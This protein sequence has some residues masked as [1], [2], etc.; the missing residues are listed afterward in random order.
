MAKMLALDLFES[1]LFNYIHRLLY[2]LNTEHRMSVNIS[3]TENVMIYWCNVKFMKFIKFTD[4]RIH[5]V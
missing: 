5:F 4:G 1:C 2:K 3:D